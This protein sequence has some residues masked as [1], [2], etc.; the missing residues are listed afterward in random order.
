[1]RNIICAHVHKGRTSRKARATEETAKL[2]RMVLV[3]CSSLNQAFQNTQIESHTANAAD[4][5]EEVEWAKVYYMKKGERFKNVFNREFVHCNALD[6]CP[7]ID[8]TVSMASRNVDWAHIMIHNNSVI[9]ELTYYRWKVLY[10]MHPTHPT[11]SFL[12]ASAKHLSSSESVIYDMYH[13]HENV[14]HFY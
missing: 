4:E 2:V 3:I 7:Q 1:M 9:P 14:Q 8:F 5:E 6:Y 12:F 10:F 13:L 11:A